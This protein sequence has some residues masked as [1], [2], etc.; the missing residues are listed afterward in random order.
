MTNYIEKNHVSSYS[1]G[2]GNFLFDRA[3]VLFGYRCD[4]TLSCLNKIS[5]FFAVLITVE[6][7]KSTKMERIN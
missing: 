2:N 6:L 4:L 1:N 5:L 7:L 3:C